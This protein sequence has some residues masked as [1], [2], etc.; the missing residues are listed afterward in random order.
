MNKINEP[1]YNEEK[2]IDVIELVESDEDNPKINIVEKNRPNH[3]EE[4]DSSSDLSS[5]LS[6]HN[7]KIEDYLNG[8]RNNAQA[9]RIPK[10]NLTFEESMGNL[11]N[12]FRKL[13]NKKNNLNTDT[14]IFNNKKF[15]QAFNTNKN[16]QLIFKLTDI[17]KEIYENQLQFKM[18]QRNC[19]IN[20]I[21]DIYINKIKK[22]SNQRK[23]VVKDYNNLIYVIGAEVYINKIETHSREFIIKKRTETF[24]GNNKVNTSEDDCYIIEINCNKKKKQKFYE[25]GEITSA[26]IM[27]L[28]NLTKDA[29]F[30]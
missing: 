15:R 3:F 7:I 22:L 28:Q 16:M 10:I 24:K 18:S 29:V 14:N 8:K 30:K 6:N 5:K 25:S 13:F 17:I 27:L 1:K 2:N 9:I 19:D 20:R 23:I 26:L 12:N 4:E 11:K 21:I